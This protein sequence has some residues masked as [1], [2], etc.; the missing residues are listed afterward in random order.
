MIRELVWD[1]TLLGKKIGRLTITAASRATLV[2]DLKRAASGG[3][4]YVTCKVQGHD[5]RIIRLLE[6]SGF[7]LSD[8]GITWQ[9]DIDILSGG[10]CVE[11]QTPET[12]RIA[13]EHDIPEIRK[14]SR[15]LF[16]QSRFYHDPFFSKRDAD[17]IYQEW[18]ENS[19]RKGAADIVF[20]L[21]NGGFITCCKKARG[22]G[23]IVLIGLRPM[24]R[25]RGYGTKMVHTALQWF[26]DNRVRNVRVRTQAKNISAM[27]FYLKSGFMVREIDI[28]YGLIL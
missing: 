25:R 22:I 28:V 7:Y 17:T 10:I 6:S 3:F 18:A 24:F 16:T 19:V 8:I 15:S 14:M 23:E 1:S 11:P 20:Y 2:A 5:E 26:S 12:I 4:A 27:N 21:P 9:K 13:D